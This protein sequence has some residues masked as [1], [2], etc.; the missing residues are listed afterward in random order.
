ME[1]GNIKMKQYRMRLFH[2]HKTEWIEW[3]NIDVP[4]NDKDILTIQFNE[5]LTIEESRE[6]F[7]HYVEKV[8]C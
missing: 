5:P 2:A 8:W 7:K 3:R 4:F 1:W 6:F